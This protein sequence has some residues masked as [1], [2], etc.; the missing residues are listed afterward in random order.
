MLASRACARSR[1]ASGFGVGGEE[2]VRFGFFMVHAVQD[3][4]DDAGMARKPIV[5]AGVHRNLVGGVEGGGA[6]APR[7]GLRVRGAGRGSVRN[8]AGGR[9]SRAVGRGP[10]G[11][12]RRA[13]RDEAGRAEVRRSGGRG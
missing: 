12:L 8:R 3:R 5:S 6:E 4:F 11:R 9:I 1:L 7:A 10:T 2:V 13:R